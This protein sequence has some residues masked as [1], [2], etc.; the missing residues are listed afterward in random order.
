MDSSSTNAA[1]F[2]QEYLSDWSGMILGV[3]TFAAK[4]RF[5]FVKILFVQVKVKAWRVYPPD[6]GVVFCDTR[7]P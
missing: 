5:F 6:L 2:G 4:S 1:C 3:E 7:T